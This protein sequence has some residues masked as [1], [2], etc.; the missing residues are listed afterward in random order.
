VPYAA[1]AFS[2][3]GYRFDLTIEDDGYRITAM[4]A[5]PGPRSFLGRRLRLHPRP[6]LSS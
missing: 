6:E 3:K 2:R 1:T 5:S 4:P